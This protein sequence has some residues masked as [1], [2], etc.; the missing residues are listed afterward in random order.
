[1]WYTKFSEIIE[2]SPVG[3][4]IEK[5][6]RALEAIDPRRIYPENIRS[7]FHIPLKLAVFLCEAAVFEGLFVKR[8][9]YVCP[10]DDCGR[11][12]AEATPD[13]SPAEPINCINCEALE[14][15]H[16][17]FDLNQC[18]KITYY[19]LRKEDLVE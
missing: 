9:G 18:R 16:Y 2:R 13:E 11:I 5:Q 14:R 19:S 12:M 10:N 8:I 17:S 4:V 7:F 1:M 15:D 3:A 6:R